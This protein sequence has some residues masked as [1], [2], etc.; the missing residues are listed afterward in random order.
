MKI[1]V[2]YTNENAYHEVISKKN[3]G[4]HVIFPKKS[5]TIKRER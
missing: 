4:K 2:R 1:K 5:Q 3:T